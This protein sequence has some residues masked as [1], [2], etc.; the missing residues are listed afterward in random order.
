MDNLVLIRVARAL[1]SDL[2]GSVLVRI[3]AEGPDRL[4]LL[5]E[6]GDRRIAIAVSLH[7]VEPWIGR[8]VGPGPRG[9]RR[10]AGPF[11]DAASRALEGRPVSKVEK[12]GPD[13]VCRLTFA[14]GSALVAELA[15]HGAN[16]VHVDSG[17]RVV[18]AA[19][20]PRSAASRF[21]VGGPYALPEIPSGRL[22]PF[23]ATPE[24]IDAFLAGVEA[25]GRDGPFE[26]LR[27]RVFGVGSRAAELVFEEA[28][29]TGRT[30]G[31]VLAARIAGLEAGE[32]DPVVLGPPEVLEAAGS[33]RLSARGIALLPWEPAVR[34][35][36]LVPTRGRDAAETAG[37]YHGAIEISRRAEARHRA[38]RAIL[39]AEVRRTWEA[40]RRVESDLS[41]FADPDRPRLWG[42]ALLAG[43]ASAR[44][45]GDEA[46]VPDPYDQAQ[47]E[48]AVPAPR[49]KRLQTV[50]EEHFR[51]HRRAV[52]GLEA[53]RARRV[54]L[55]SR[56]A[57]LERLAARAESARGEDEAEAIE[58]EMR[59][60]RIPV[61]LGPGTRAAREAARGSRPRVEG[62]RI[63]TSRDGLTIL[64]GRS[65]KDN[66]RLTFR[67]AALEDV[68]L[69]AAGVPG[70]HVVVRTPGEAALPPRG[71]LEEA[72]AIAAWY[73]EA[74]GSGAVDVVW[75]RRKHVRRKR[76][77]PPG[78]VT[79]KRFE[80]LRVRP[81]LPAG[82]GEGAAG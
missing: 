40:G 39:A 58:E 66:D 24:A 2:E 78:T 10:P 15:T 7:P 43:L 9:P 54:A 14:D 56:L 51:A 22:V 20:R 31:E 47:R 67:I 3:L 69:H 12:A 6:K 38:L 45:V 68:W 37:L 1:S 4:R 26:A 35:P 63:L 76:G 59:A 52:R 25:E 36:G 30:P 77:A 11:A 62:V 28:S 33:G 50:A 74:R 44:R 29:R 70:A 13:R 46:I 48:I 81:A 73:S 41:T 61:G 53:A 79:L 32:W 42:E 57:R 18:G 80:T 55:E 49:G 17:G 65:G 21:V 71:T 23:G 82:G 34:E 8:P 19:R 60:E 16:L 27:R 64:V 72:A 5:F 75:A